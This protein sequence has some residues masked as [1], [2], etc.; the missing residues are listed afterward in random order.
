MKPQFCIKTVTPNYLRRSTI[1]IMCAYNLEYN[2]ILRL[3]FSNLRTIA[4]GIE[5]YRICAE[6]IYGGRKTVGWANCLPM[7]NL[8]RNRMGRGTCPSYKLF[9]K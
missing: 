2:V 4:E 7:L 8:N 9:A 6:S 3:F 5:I 1:G